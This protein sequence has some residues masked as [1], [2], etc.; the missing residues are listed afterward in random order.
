AHPEVS[1]IPLPVPQAELVQPLETVG[2][3]IGPY[4]LLERLGE[5]GAG[6]VYKARHQRMDRIAA[7]KVIRAELLTDD[8]M[9]RRFYREVE[10]VSQLQHPNIVHA[11]DAGPIME[12][13]RVR[14]H[15]LAMEYLEGVDLARLGKQQGPLPVSESR[16]YIRQASLGL[17]YIH[18]HGM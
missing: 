13:E 1:P 17:Q 10:A 5:G 12:E 16:E 18:E 7:V 3:A 15:F 2:A 14:G 8:D 11:Y 9:I 4:I 6:Q